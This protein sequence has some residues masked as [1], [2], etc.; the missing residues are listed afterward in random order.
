MGATIIFAIIGFVFLLI[1]ILIYVF[2]IV[3]I[4]A[5]YDASKVKDKDGLARWFGRV[6]FINSIAA[7]VLAAITFKIQSDNAAIS[8]FA[9]FM[10]FTMISGVMALYG[11][12]K[13][14]DK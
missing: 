13:Y 6:V 7:F 10:V 12:Q 5:G 1:S 8:S 9:V 14:M 11:V 2:K 3:N 4:I